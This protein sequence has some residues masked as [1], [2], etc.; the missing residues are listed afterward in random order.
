MTHTQALCLWVAPIFGRSQWLTLYLSLRLQSYNFSG[1]QTHAHPIFELW[2][3]NGLGVVW[4]SKDK[5]LAEWK[6]KEKILKWKEFDERMKN[7]PRGACCGWGHLLYWGWFR[8][9]Q[10][11]L[12]HQRVLKFSVLI[13]VFLIIVPVCLFYYVFF[14][15]VWIDYIGHWFICTTRVPWGTR[16]S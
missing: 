3:N 10:G 5:I 7:S 9:H 12:G 16:E 11:S 8:D 14:V 13:Y 4:L 2:S 6:S 15:L 1:S